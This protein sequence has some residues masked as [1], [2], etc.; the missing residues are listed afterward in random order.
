M[1]DTQAIQ[2]PRLWTLD[3]GLWTSPASNSHAGRRACLR[4]ASQIVAMATSVLALRPMTSVT[5]VAWK[6][7]VE[8]PTALRQTVVRPQS[9]A[10]A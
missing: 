10:L 8:V 3:F 4:S 9:I 6:C 7:S 5:G 2:G 1:P